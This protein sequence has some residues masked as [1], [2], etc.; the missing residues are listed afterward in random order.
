MKTQSSSDEHEHNIGDDEVG[1]HGEQEEDQED[2]ADNSESVS[3]DCGKASHLL[4]QYR[5][6][7]RNFLSLSLALSSASVVVVVVVVVVALLLLMLL[8][9]IFLS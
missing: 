1:H 9:N 2:G 3:E 6:H 5:N 4:H 8:L 7:I